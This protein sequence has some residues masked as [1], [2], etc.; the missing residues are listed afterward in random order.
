AVYNAAPAGEKIEDVLKKAKADRDALAGVWE[1]QRQLVNDE[2][3]KR[4][5]DYY[6]WNFTGYDVVIESKVGGE[7]RKAD[8]TFSVNP[9]TAPPE[10]TIYGQGTLIMGVYELKGDVLKVACFGISEL[11]RPRGFTAKDRRVPD[12]K[13]VVW[14]VSCSSCMWQLMR[15]K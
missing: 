2:E 10:L 8:L 9:T 6:R 4:W 5:F 13:L 3:Q 11:E 15:G 14:V 7:E 1:L 12:M